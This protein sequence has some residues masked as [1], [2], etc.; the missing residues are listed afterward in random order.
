MADAMS[1]LYG[2]TAQAQENLGRANYYNSITPERLAAAQLRSQTAED[3]LGKPVA[4]KDGNLLGY[5]GNDNQF[6][7]ASEYG[8]PA[9]ASINTPNRSNTPQYNQ[10]ALTQRFINDDMTQKY[11]PD[12]SKWPPVPTNTVTGAVTKAKNLLVVQP[13][14]AENANRNNAPGGPV[15]RQDTQLQNSIYNR[16]DSDVAQE[17]KRYQLAM[18]APMMNDP[19]TRQQADTEHQRNLQ[20]AAQFR[21]DQLG[22][23]QQRQQPTQ[24]PASQTSP[25]QSPNV[26]KAVGAI[27]HLPKDQQAGYVD[28][29]TSLTAAEKRAVKQTLGL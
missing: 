3:K 24:R 28:S 23:L 27:Q 11:G 10:E 22:R 20:T 14:I 2:T 1:K 21:D 6:H 15:D 7:P 12:Q 17:N 29:S 26:Q 19:A 13:N 9:G 25:A 16:Y 4:D 18:A 5:M 8:I